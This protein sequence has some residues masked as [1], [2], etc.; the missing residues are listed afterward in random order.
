MAR[1]TDRFV[2]YNFFHVHSDTLSVSRNLDS[3]TSNIGTQ[4]SH[5]M[6]LARAFYSFF[7]TNVFDHV[8]VRT[9]QK[10]T[11][12]GFLGVGSGVRNVMQKF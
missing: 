8:D 7:H 11:R 2:H 9:P 5:V 4:T 6:M 3:K 12:C 1:N 10:F